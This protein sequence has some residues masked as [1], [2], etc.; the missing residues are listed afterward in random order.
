MKVRDFISFTYASLPLISR[1]H[2]QL[3]GKKNLL[4]RSTSVPTYHNPYTSCYCMAKDHMILKPLSCLCHGLKPRLGYE[5]YSPKSLT[6][7]QTLK[8]IP[9]VFRW[10]YGIQHSLNLSILHAKVRRIKTMVFNTIVPQPFFSPN[11][12]M[13][14][15]C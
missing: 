13:Q 15:P 4:P 10:D 3:T 12:V 7:K 14:I 6:F 2:C 5:R 11:F 8:L 1:L 9:C